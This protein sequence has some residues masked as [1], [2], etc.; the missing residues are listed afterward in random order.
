MGS[1]LYFADQGLTA[2]D[3]VTKALVFAGLE[4]KSDLSVISHVY[5]NIFGVAPQTDNLAFWVGIIEGNNGVD[6]SPL[7]A[8]MANL[9]QN[10]ET[11]GLN[12]M[13]HIS[14]IPV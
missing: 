14:Y 13:D 9:D 12:Q 3:L 11:I 7:I 1:G 10:I 8:A 5:E 2:S 6:R 4:E